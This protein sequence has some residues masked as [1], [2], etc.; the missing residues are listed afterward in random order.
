[1][2]RLQVYFWIWY[3]RVEVDREQYKT[4]SQGLDVVAQLTNFNKNLKAEK[5][6]AKSKILLDGFASLNQ[7]M[8]AQEDDEDDFDAV[9][10][11]ATN[12]TDGQGNAA[13]QMFQVFDANLELKKY[14]KNKQF[15][16]LFSIYKVNLARN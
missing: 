4:Y 3:S 7:N 13:L 8:L 6:R 2:K 14:K 9:A 15:K 12:E 10:V 5:N 11:K 1:M 16:H